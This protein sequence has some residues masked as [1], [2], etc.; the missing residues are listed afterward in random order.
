MLLNYFKFVFLQSNYFISFFKECTKSN[1]IRH[2]KTCMDKSRNL[3][4]NFHKKEKDFFNIGKKK[5][6]QYN[7]YVLQLT[8]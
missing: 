2:K 1:F 8:F 3:K 5:K 4:R 7:N 6:K